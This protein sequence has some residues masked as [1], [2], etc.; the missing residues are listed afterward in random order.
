MKYN[1][2]EDLVDSAI[3]HALLAKCGVEP[4]DGDE[5][6]VCTAPREHRAL[7]LELREVLL[8]ELRAEGY[9]PN[10]F[11][12]LD[13]VL[14]YQI[15]GSHYKG[16][17][18]QHLKYALANDLPYAE[19]AVMKYLSRNGKKGDEGAQD[20]DKAIHIILAIRAARYPGAP[21]SPFV[22]Q[23]GSDWKTAL[24]TPVPQQG[25]WTGGC[26]T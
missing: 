9:E 3:R 14:E 21:A 1:S 7:L 23:R 19:G 12:L 4:P 10:P 25:G 18:I 5:P 24:N 17:V 13:R 22:F 16:Q 20:L 11:A 6:S 2:L 8:Q 15:G 26:T